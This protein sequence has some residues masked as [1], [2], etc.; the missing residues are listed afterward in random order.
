MLHRSL[1]FVLV[2]LSACE[3]GVAPPECTERLAFV[4]DRDHTTSLN[5]TEIYTISP[6]GSDERRV[7][8]TQFFNDDP[9][10]S[11][12]GRQLVFQ[13]TRDGNNE[14]YSMRANGA[15]S[16]ASH[17]R[18][19]GRLSTSVVSGWRENPVPIRPARRERRRH[20]PDE[21]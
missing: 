4:S 10:W 11:P 13:S 19:A 21:C 15:V 9:A 6:D 12:D 2:A 8:V 14:I 7:T 17:R 5:L 1:A 20:L 16:R 18:A 3:S